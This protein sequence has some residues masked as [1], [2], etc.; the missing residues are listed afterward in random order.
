M[1]R[2][3][4]TVYH[5]VEGSN[6][7]SVQQH[8]LM[9][10]RRLMELY[11]ASDS[12]AWRRH[13]P[14]SQ[15][16]AQGVLLRDQKPMPPGALARCL[17]NGLTPPDWFEPLNSKIFFWLDPRRL[18]RQRLARKASPQIALVID[19]VRLLV[20]YGC[21]ATVTPINSGN[22]LRAAARRNLSTFVPYERWRV[23]GWEFEDVPGTGRRDPNHRP[24]ELAVNDAVPDIMDYV[25]SV[26]PLRAGET[27]E[28]RGRADLAP[29]SRWK[30]RLS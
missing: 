3:I 21:Y 1:P 27:L 20:S 17:T 15:R 23:D 19:A 30:C 9:S 24:V 22:A 10:A 28:G 16:L 26:A 12:S 18:N 7:V 29:T 8:G 25:V 5:L 11:Q 6:W 2:T 14:T 4:D 13:R